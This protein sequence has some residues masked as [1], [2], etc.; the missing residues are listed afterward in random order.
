MNLFKLI[1]PQ[2]RTKLN[3]LKRTLVEGSPKY[4]YDLAAIAAGAQ[5]YIDLSTDYPLARK[6]QPLDT[7]LIINNDAVGISLVFNS[8]ASAPYI[9]PAGVI[10]TISRDEVGAIWNI[11]VTNLDALAA[12]VVN[13]IDFEIW[14]SPEEATDILRREWGAH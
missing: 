7:I 11:T 8:P 9:I 5:A 14:K 6:Y 2:A 12:V 13:M 4:H 10:R 1:S 3:R